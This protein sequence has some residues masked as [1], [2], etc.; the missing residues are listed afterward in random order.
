MKRIAVVLAL[1]VLAIAGCKQIPKHTAKPTPL[2]PPLPAG[3]SF[4][5]LTAS[6]ATSHVEPTYVPTD[7]AL[8][9]VRIQQNSVI[10]SWQNGTPP[11][12]PQS[13]PDLLSDWVDFGPST[14]QRSITNFAPYGFTKAFFR[15]KSMTQTPGLFQWTRQGAS[16]N[17]QGSAKSVTVDRSGNVINAG[18][19]QGSIDFGGGLWTSIGKDA[20]VVK[21]SPQGT[22][23]WIKRFGGTLDDDL[24]SVATDVLDN[25]V[26]VGSFA[27]TVDFGGISLTSTSGVFGPSQDIFVA[28]YSPSGSLMWVKSFGGNQGDNGTAVAVDNSGNVF[29]AGIF[30]SATIN[31][32]GIIINNGPSSG[33]FVLAKLSASGSTLWAKGWG[34]SGVSAPSNLAIDKAGELCVV[35]SF[36]DSTDLGAGN[37]P[38]AGGTDI[39]VAKY[40]GATG[41]HIWSKTV[42]TASLSSEAGNGIATDA[43]SG[44]IIIT[45]QYG[46]AANF[47]CPILDF[48]G[49]PNTVGGIFLAAYDS[50]GTCLWARTPNVSASGASDEAGYGVCVDGSGD[51]YYTGKCSSPVYF[52]G[53]FLS[54]GRD[55]FTA[56]ITSSA[57]YRWAKRSGGASGVG[58]DVAV[59]DLGHVMMAGRVSGGTMNFDRLLGPSGGSVTTGQATIAP[60]VVQ[61]AK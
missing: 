5:R 9:S 14:A 30:I 41:N 31:I 61:F 50:A 15:V 23:V 52:G 17:F 18:S 40:S 29:W 54:G 11:F 16:V 59:D 43:S 46:G 49:N 37:R 38:S 8:T 45:G 3:A 55:L 7:F 36:G 22:T 47:G 10:L 21:Y 27:G 20:F 12:Q 56:S 13:K 57:A 32:G 53:G 26:V 51:I 60:F 33:N 28:K 34:G 24:Q 35:G 19:W 2:P 1:T 44:N 48:G 39:F 6:V 42:G 58:A 25:I 4:K